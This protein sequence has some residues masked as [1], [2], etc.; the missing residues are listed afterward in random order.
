MGGL[1]RLGQDSPGLRKTA[2]PTRRFGA[3]L[4]PTL[5]RAAGGVEN[6]RIWHRSLRVDESNLPCL[7]ARKET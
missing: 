4:A 2:N 7:S 1:R 6:R 3:I 5:M